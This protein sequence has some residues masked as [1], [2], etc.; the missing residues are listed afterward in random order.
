VDR[1]FLRAM[2]NLLGFADII[3]IERAAFARLRRA[4]GALDP[5][6]RVR[7]LPVQDNRNV[8]EKAHFF[9]LQ[10]ICDEQKKWRGIEP[11]VHEL[12][13]QFTHLHHLLGAILF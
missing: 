12:G 5:P 7:A 11:Y 2:V 6:R 1:A 4:R 9:S 8:A 3:V 10:L 13:C